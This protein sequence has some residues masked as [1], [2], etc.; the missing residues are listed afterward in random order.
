MLP[1]HNIFCTYE[2]FSLAT[3]L[4]GQIKKWGESGGK[5]CKD[6]FIP[7][8]PPPSNLT[9]SQIKVTDS[10]GRYRF[11]PIFITQI[12]RKSLIATICILIP[13]MCPISVVDIRSGLRTRN[14]QSQIQLMKRIIR[15]A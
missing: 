9:P 6:W 11:S 3:E 15:T 13:K 10:H 1:P 7:M 2:Y 4:E 8:F 14:L 12:M 5:G